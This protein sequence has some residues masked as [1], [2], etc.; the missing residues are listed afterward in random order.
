MRRGR[1]REESW[2]NQI[3]RVGK[4]RGL[5]TLRTMGPPVAIYV[6][7]WI[8][9]GLYPT[10]RK[11]Y[12]N[13]EAAKFPRAFS[14]LMIPNEGGNERDAWDW[15]G[16]PSWGSAFAEKRRS[17]VRRAELEEDT[18]ETRPPPRSAS[19]QTYAKDIYSLR[20]RVR[21][22]PERDLGDRQLP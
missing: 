11:T 12:L 19:P 4:T 13:H 10:Y 1:G 5:N 16:F 15:S 17:D 9:L 20:Q 6:R 3:S 8:D 14:Q 7:T 22:H 18:L 21:Q 2:E